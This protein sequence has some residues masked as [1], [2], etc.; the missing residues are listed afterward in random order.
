MNLLLREDEF[1]CGGLSVVDE[2][3]NKS[4]DQQCGDD[5]G[6]E[7]FASGHGLVPSILKTCDESHYYEPDGLLE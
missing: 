1:G 3:G 6:C 7:D 5:D 2:E 4:R